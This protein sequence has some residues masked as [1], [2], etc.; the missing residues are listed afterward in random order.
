M[1]KLYTEKSR[2]ERADALLKNDI[3]IEAMATIKEKIISAWESSP[4]RDVEGQ[5]KLRFML[6]AYKGLKSAIE[7]IV[8]TGKLASLQIANEESKIKKRRKNSP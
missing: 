3:F 5:Q 8:Q 7:E 2:G 6:D 1:S 4:L